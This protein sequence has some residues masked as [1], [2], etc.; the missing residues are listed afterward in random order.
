MS[1]APIPPHH[2]LAL[3]DNTLTQENWQRELQAAYRDPLALLADLDVSPE[4][5]DLS[6]EA[7][8]RFA[9]RVPRPFAARMRPRDPF[10]PLLRQVI[11][12]AGELASHAGFVADPVSDL[13]AHPIPGLLH[14]YAGRVL[15]IVTGACAVNCRY[16]FRRQFPYRETS[17]P[18]RWRAALDY[19]A[20]DASISEVIL[21]GGDPLMLKDKPLHELVRAIDSIDHVETLRVHTRMPIGIPARVTPTLLNTLTSGRL[22]SVL[23]LHANHANEIDHEVASALERVYAARIP[24][25]SQTVL[26]R[27]INDDA[28]T[29][30]QLARTLFDNGVIP[31][32]IHQLDPVAGA[33][34]FDTPSAQVQALAQALRATLPGY[35]VPRLVREVAGAAAKIPIV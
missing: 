9:F 27:G 32:Y 33:A 31:Y 3:N 10:D 7:A 29:L 21:S 17:G 28:G 15:L 20:N 14:K 11:P 35:L 16:C 25:F 13:A 2:M 8:R 4:Q 18:E 22:K 34:H 12:S 5:V 1:N 19:V 30:A 6:S 24:M 23:V 26:L